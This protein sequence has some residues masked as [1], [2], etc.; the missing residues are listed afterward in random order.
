M[1]LKIASV[2]PLV[3]VTSASASGRCPYTRSL[4]AAIACRSDATPVIGAYWLWPARIARSSSSTRRGGTSKSGKPWPRLTAPCSCASCDI[5]VKMVVPTFGS[6]LGNIDIHPQRIREA[7]S[8][9]PGPDRLNLAPD[10]DPPGR[11]RRDASDDAAARLP[12]RGVS[13]AARRR[14]A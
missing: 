8:L 13:L 2:A 9:R 1:A 4:L 3:T 7:G 10:V 14:L 6:L 11:F 5:T 12:G